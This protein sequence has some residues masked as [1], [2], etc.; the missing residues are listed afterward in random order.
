MVGD[1][2]EGEGF[3]FFFEGDMGGAGLDG[4]WDVQAVACPVGWGF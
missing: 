1:V 4:R 2:V 3:F